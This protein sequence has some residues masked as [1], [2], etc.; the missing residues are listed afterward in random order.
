MVPDI[1]K[2]EKE[3]TSLCS[4]ETANIFEKVRLVDPNKDSYYYIMS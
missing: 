2:L 4:L 3:R 1:E